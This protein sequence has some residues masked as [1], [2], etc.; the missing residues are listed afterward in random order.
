MKQ[1]EDKVKVLYNLQEEN[2]DIEQIIKYKLIKMVIIQ[3]ILLE[4]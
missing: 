4:I 2:K 1:K 3:T